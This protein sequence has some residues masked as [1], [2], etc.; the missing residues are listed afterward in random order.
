MNSLSTKLFL[1]TPAFI[2]NLLITLHNFSKSNYR[3]GG[4][5]KE[6]LEYYAGKKN[7]SEKELN[8]EN[9]EKLK[10]FLSF[11]KTHSSYYNNILKD[12]DIAGIVSIPD[13]QTIP[14]LTK[15]NIQESFESIITISDKDAIVGKTGGTTGTSLHVYYTKNDIQERQALLDNF[16]ARYGYKHG[17]KTAWFS[18]KNLINERDK[19]NH[20]F[21][22]TDFLYHVRYYSTFHIQAINF[23]YYIDNL[24]DYKP[25]FLVGFPSSIYDIAA[26][27]IAN[28]ISFPQGVVKAVFP[29]AEKITT[30]IRAV[31]EQFFHT[32]VVDQYASSEGAPFI[33]ECE[34]GNLHLDLL[35]GVFEV[36]DENNCPADSG[37]LIVTSFTTHGT[38]LIRYDI[39]DGLTLSDEKCV[40]GNNN[41][42]VKEIDGRINDFIYSDETGKINLGNIS[43]C[44]KGVTGIEK[45]QIIQNEKNAIDV[46]VVKSSE[47]FTKHDEIVFIQNLRERL[48]DTITIN[49][50]YV[51]DIEHELSGKFRMVKNNLKEKI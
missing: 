23:K 50:N 22:K 49:M 47:L 16:R 19:K 43:N 42:V 40:C 9:I 27:G 15:K 31:I 25:E 7:L 32:R 5:Y 14:L 1:Y 3:K 26:F 11:A 34:H 6:K 28:N 12:F 39:G 29:T 17:K 30:E 37:R 46:L 51:P 20:V 45:F 4:I 35:T 2:Q 41:P 24:V 33:F 10:N 38:P 21:W 13:L 48:G 36:L 44:M 8:S 18:G